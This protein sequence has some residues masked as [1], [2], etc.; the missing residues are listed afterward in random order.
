MAIEYITNPM[1][2]RPEHHFLMRDGGWFRPKAGGYT[3]DIG[4]AGIFTAAEVLDFLKAE[5]VK[6]VPVRTMKDDIWKQAQESLAKSAHLFDLAFK[7]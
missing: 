4:E 6:A 2:I 7:L 5:G 1:K 3:R